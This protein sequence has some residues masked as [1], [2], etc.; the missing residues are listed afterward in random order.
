L[1]SF[2]L[3]LVSLFVE[4]ARTWPKF[5]T[6]EVSPLVDCFIRCTKLARQSDAVFLLTL[7][8]MNRHEDFMHSTLGA[9]ADAIPVHGD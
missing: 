3:A 8:V 1:D 5:P 6:A 7:E 2:D 4:L 9:L